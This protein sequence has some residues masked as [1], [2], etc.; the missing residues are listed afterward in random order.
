LHFEWGEKEPG[1]EN[2]FEIEESCCASV[3]CKRFDNV[4]CVKR[5]CLDV[6]ATAGQLYAVL[7]MAKL[8]FFLPPRGGRREG[9]RLQSAEC[10][11]DKIANGLAFT[12]EGG[13]GEAGVFFW[14]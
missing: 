13:G 11:P 14:V 1:A 5:C 3:R 4:S 12:A 7:P 2:R 9:N 10:P 6:E 8:A